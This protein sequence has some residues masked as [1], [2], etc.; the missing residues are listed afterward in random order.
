MRGVVHGVWYCMVLHGGTAGYCT[1]SSRSSGSS[2]AS[3]RARRARRPRCSRSAAARGTCPNVVTFCCSTSISSR[4]GR[5]SADCT[6][7]STV[8]ESGTAMG[9]GLGAPGEVA[10][11]GPASGAFCRCL[12]P[13]RLDCGPFR[14]PCCRAMHAGAADGCCPRTELLGAD[15]AQSGRPPRPVTRARAPQKVARPPWLFFFHSVT[16][17][18]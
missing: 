18:V 14:P 8:E 17:L 5:A 4:V 2:T 11:G 6:V 3:S 13:L 7:T 10:S 12:V 1:S 16:V 9:I 15:Q